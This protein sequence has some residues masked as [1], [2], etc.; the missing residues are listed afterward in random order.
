MSLPRLS[1]PEIR[2]RSRAERLL[3]AR[4]TS[5]LGKP[6]AVRLTRN[7]KRLLS[8]R[9]DA[10]GNRTLRAHCAL[11]EADADD[12]RV[13]AAWIRDDPGAGAAARTL[14]SKFRERIDAVTVLRS[15]TRASGGP[16]VHHDLNAMLRALLDRYFP[17]LPQ[18]YIAWSGRAGGA[19]RRRLGSWNPRERLIRMHCVLDRPE[20]PAHFVAHVIHHELCHAAADPPLTPTGRRRIHGP[21]FRRLEAQFE[22][23]ERARAW[24]RAHGR[25]LLR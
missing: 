18:V 19:T 17:N 13:I 8:L 12:L 22:D 16:G 24:E 25:L 21:E 20:V 5:V 1:R 15:G 6:I 9:S 4:L 2:E 14:F 10:K 7:G 3:A 11:A 23:L